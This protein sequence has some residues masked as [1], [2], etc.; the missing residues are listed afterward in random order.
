M[1]YVAN[2]DETPAYLGGKDNT[3]RQL[4]LDALPRHSF[5]HNLVEYLE[6]RGRGRESIERLASLTRPQ[7]QT[8]QAHIIK[9]VSSLRWVRTA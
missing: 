8:E 5:L 1:Q 9:T 7:T 2:M 3:W 4:N 6:E